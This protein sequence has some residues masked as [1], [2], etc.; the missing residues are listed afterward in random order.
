M[1][2]AIIAATVG[3][4]VGCSTNKI[5][6]ELNETRKV[7]VGTPIIT[8]TT[9][10][11][12]LVAAKSETNQLIYNGFE[13]REILASHIQRASRLSGEHLKTNV[14]GTDSLRLTPDESGIVHF[15][16]VA[17]RVVSVEP[18]GLTY[19]LVSAPTLQD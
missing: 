9:G 13:G 2:L 7:T 6:V 19:T 10:K 14:Y 3:L 8:W 5:S 17:F 18:S 15:R 1:R 16:D 4:F 12:W 11:T